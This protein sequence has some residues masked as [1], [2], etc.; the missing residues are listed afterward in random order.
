MLLLSLAFA[1]AGAQPSYQMSDMTATFKQAPGASHVKIGSVGM[2]FAS[3]FT[4]TMGVKSVEVYEIDP[5]SDEQQA[6]INEQMSHL[7]DAAY[8][9]MVS[10]NE[11][12]ER[13][14]IW[15]KTD[16]KVIRELIIVSAGSSCALVR[17]KG[18]ISPERIGQV[19]D[20]YDDAD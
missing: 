15:L 17:I 16:K 2:W 7:E 10:A 3:L 4:K 5:C 18:K 19:I 8:E 9:V 14:K 20:Q 1:A 12:D 11:P 6:L 13:T